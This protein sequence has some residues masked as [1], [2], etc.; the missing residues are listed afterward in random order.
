MHAPDFGVI[1]L[2]GTALSLAIRSAV[3]A[4][5]T[6]E[7]QRNAAAA[8][9]EAAKAIALESR[10]VDALEAAVDAGLA[11]AQLTG[12]AAQ[13]WASHHRADAPD[14]AP[15]LPQAPRPPRVIW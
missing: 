9:E 14:D 11:P 1:V 7:I 12:L 6:E 15:V 3:V 13:A 8:G 4:R 2:A 5:S 10:I